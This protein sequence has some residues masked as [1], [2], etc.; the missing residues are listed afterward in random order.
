MVQAPLE[1]AVRYCWKLSVVPEES[2]RTIAVI[3]LVRQGGAAVERGDGRVVPLL[4]AAVEDLGGDLAVEHQVVD[5]V[6][7]V[8]DGDGAEDQRQVPGLVAG[9]TL[10]GRCGLLGLDGGVGAGEVDLAWR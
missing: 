6:E 7:V 1:A 3:V 9:A 10:L 2:E 5:A 8:G 4:D